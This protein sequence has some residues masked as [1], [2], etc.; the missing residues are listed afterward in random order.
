[1]PLPDGRRW[2]P[3]GGLQKHRERIHRE[4]KIAD[5]KK[6]PYVFSKPIRKSYALFEC[7]ECGRVF[8]AAKNTVMVICST[9]K[10]LTRAKQ[11]D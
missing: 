4:S 7:E 3:E 10:K 6:L 8:S 2:I 5:N 9:C 1:M 11:I